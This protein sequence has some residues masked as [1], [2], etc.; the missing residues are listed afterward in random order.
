MEHIVYT[1]YARMRDRRDG[2]S[3]SDEVVLG[4][5][6]S[7]LRLRKTMDP[8]RVVDARPIAKRLRVPL[9]LVM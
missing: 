5:A 4:G 8:R 6:P 7:E 2:E 9:G 1:A 3:L